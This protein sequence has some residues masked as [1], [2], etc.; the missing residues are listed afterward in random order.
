[1]S[2]GHAILPPAPLLPAISFSTLAVSH[3]TLSLVAACAAEC[4]AALHRHIPTHLPNPCAPHH[5]H[6]C[7]TSSCVPGCILTLGMRFPTSGRH[8]V[9]LGCLC[10]EVRSVTAAAFGLTMM[11]GCWARGCK[12]TNNRCAHTHEW[13]AW[14]GTR[15]RSFTLLCH[16]PY[17]FFPS[18]AGQAPAHPAGV[19]P[20]SLQRFF[21]PGWSFPRGSF[22]FPSSLARPRKLVVGNDL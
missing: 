15:A 10:C 20:L 8:P 3:V 19:R 7:I 14:C 16:F 22:G 1:M 9:A 11:G 17:Q 18:P 6:V 4:W 13:I 12:H 21:A 2:L 5:A